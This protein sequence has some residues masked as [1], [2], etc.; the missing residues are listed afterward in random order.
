MSNPST[1]TKRGTLLIIS[2]ALLFSIVFFVV[3]L[4]W[5]L[6]ISFTPSTEA[7][8]NEFTL[9]LENYRR[10]LTDEYFVKHLLWRTVWLSIL[11]TIAAVI[12]GYIGALVIARAPVKWQATLLFLVMCPLWVNLVVRTLSLM[13]LLGRDGPLNKFLMWLGMTEKPI[14]LLFNETAVLIGMVQVSVPFVVIA[15]HGVLKSIPESL[16]HSAMTVGANPLQ[17]FL[18]VTLPLSVPGIMAGSVLA[19]GLNMESFVVP[20]L[21]GGGRIHFMSV[22]AYEIATVGNNLPFAATIGMV[23]LIVTLAILGVYQYILK[24]M[25]KV[26]VALRNT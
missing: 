1:F 8:G 9:T 21:L 11:A 20:I 13:I 17:A 26:S 19:L 22:E 6:A 2:P 16:E 25:N 7:L 4:L 14:Q 15:L 5:C 18:R 10:F 12:V 23:L 24:S 3:P